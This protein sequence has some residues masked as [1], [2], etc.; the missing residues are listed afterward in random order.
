MQVYLESD[1]PSGAPP[2]PLGIVGCSLARPRFGAAVALS[3]TIQVVAMAD[4]DARFAKA[5]SRTLSG[6]ISLFADLPSLLAHES[7]PPALIIEVPL[8]ERSEA[9]LAAIPVCR[10]ILC[11]PPFAPTLEETD[12]ILHA[13]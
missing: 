12:H 11:A 4:P 6:D 7:V 3:K 5:W 8:N 9:L 10:G 2:L 1:T 13:A